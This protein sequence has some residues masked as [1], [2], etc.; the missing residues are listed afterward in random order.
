MPCIDEWDE[1]IKEEEK[2]DKKRVAL[3][4]VMIRLPEDEKKILCD[5]L[6]EYYVEK[7]YADDLLNEYYLEKKDAV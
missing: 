4:Q 7:K 6:N 5:L 3:V 1:T 2:K